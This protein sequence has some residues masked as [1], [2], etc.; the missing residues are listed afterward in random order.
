VTAANLAAYSRALDEIF[1]LRRA[2]AI[3]A[4]YLAV[5]LEM[6]TFP[7]SR[8]LYSENLV[9]EMRAFARGEGTALYRELRAHQLRWAQ[10]SAGT[11]NGPTVDSWLAEEHTTRTLPGQEATE[12]DPELLARAVA[13]IRMLRT[14][15]ARFWLLSEVPLEYSSYP[16]TRLPVTV[17]QVERLKLCSHGKVGIAYAGFDDRELYEALPS[18]G[19][20]YGLT[21]G[22]WEAELERS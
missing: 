12:I 4:G 7:K 11:L 17:G 15:A 1:F 20:P 16:K 14:M 22:M 6:K 3:E 8:R 19:A 21:R 9:E 18:A 13:E 5:S 2:F 10:D